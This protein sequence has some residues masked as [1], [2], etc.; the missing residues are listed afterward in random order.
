MICDVLLQFNSVFLTPH[1]RSDR[2][3]V[4][5]IIG[6]IDG[7]EEEAGEEILKEELLLVQLGAFFEG[8]DGG[9]G[10]ARRDEDRDK[11]GKEKEKEG[12]S[13]GGTEANEIR[14][15]A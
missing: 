14:G 4:G 7:E 11:K 8:D 3:E 1:S 13:G 6:V 5:K 9:E 10:D 15:R 12:E 2:G